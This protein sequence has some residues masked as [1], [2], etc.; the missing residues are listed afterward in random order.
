MNKNA[1]FG[2]HRKVTAVRKEQNRLILKPYVCNRVRLYDTNAMSTTGERWT[3]EP[4]RAGIV[5]DAYSQD[6]EYRSSCSSVRSRP[7]TTRLP[8]PR[9]GWQ[10]H[11]QGCAAEPDL[12]RRISEMPQPRAL[13]AGSV[14]GAGRVKQE[15]LE[16]RLC[17]LLPRSSSSSRPCPRHPPRYIPRHPPR[18]KHLNTLNRRTIHVRKILAAL[19]PSP[20]QVR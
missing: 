9:R 13:A 8:C 19:V 14:S 15:S 4:S 18:N 5:L 17:I 2:L 11:Q 7:R 12:P 3:S 10:T 20:K 1:M 16:Q 6:P